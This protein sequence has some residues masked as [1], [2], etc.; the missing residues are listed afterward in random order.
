MSGNLLWIHQ[1]FLF[2]VTFHPFS[3]DVFENHIYWVSPEL[4]EVAMADK[5]GRG[6]NETIQAGL[7]MPHAIKIFQEDI[8]YDLTSK[9]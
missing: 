6:I 4:G 2:V 3:I 9:N 5:F 1:H 7:P 8:R